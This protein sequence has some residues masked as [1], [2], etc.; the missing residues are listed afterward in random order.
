[1]QLHEITLGMTR[2]DETAYSLF[3]Q[4]YHPRI[5][6][7]VYVLVSGRS[8]EA[9]DITQE[10]LL[11]VI[12]HIREFHSEEIF[13]DWLTCLARSAA[14]DHRRKSGRWARWLKQIWTPPP[15]CP[16]R[17]P[18]VDVTQFVQ[19]AVALLPEDDQILLAAKY[20]GRTTRELAH[21][22]GQTEGAIE[23]RLVRLRARIREQVLE[24]RRHEAE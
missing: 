21:E 8:D 24:W 10:T 19:R 16:P 18:E 4:E 17:C 7:Y 15:A 23:S 13:W 6:R 12:R 5:Y 20:S 2:G 3:H 22:R 1:M 11:R 14:Q 9:L